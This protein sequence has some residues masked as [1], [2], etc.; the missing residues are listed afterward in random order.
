MK[1]YSASIFYVSES[2]AG[3]K[4]AKRLVCVHDLT[5]F[6]YFQQNSIRE[7]MNFSG[8][9]LAEKSEND[10]HMSVQENDYVCHVHSCPNGIVGI[11]ISDAEYPA[12]VAL[13]IV[14]KFTED[15]TKKFS[16]DT[17]KSTTSN[18]LQFKDIDMVLVKYQDPKSADQILRLQSSVEQTKEIMHCNFESLLKRDEKLDDLVAQSEELSLS[19]KAFYVTAKKTNK[20]CAI[21]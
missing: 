18:T 6:G 2:E 14:A 9:V 10:R 1:L 12:R 20:C 4:A 17:C 8:K 15:F 16:I 19:A 21:I 11:L 13:S 3:E 7:F 5:S